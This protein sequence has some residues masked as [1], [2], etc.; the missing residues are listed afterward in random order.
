[1][2]GNV[3]E[4]TIGAAVIAIAVAFFTY[5]YKT[6]DIRAGSGGYTIKANFENIDGINTGSDVRVSGIKVGSVVEQRLDTSTFEAAVVFAIDP[7][8]KLPADSSAKVT[9]EGLLGDKYIAIEPGG[10]EEMLA[11]GG[12]IEHTQGALDLFGMISSFLFSGNDKKT[13]ETKQDTT[14]Q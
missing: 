13:D 1:M 11:E 9:S 12:I 2:K 8:V 3:V 14:T 10:D 4:T 5:V 7:G 6:A